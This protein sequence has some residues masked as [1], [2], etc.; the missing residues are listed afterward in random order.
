[1]HTRNRSRSR[2][3]A[4]NGIVRAFLLTAP[5]VTAFATGAPA[6]VQA[7]VRGPLALA[8]KPLT[9]GELG[10][11][12]GGFAFGGFDIDVGVVARSVIDQTLASVGNIGERLEV[13]TR[14]TVP[15]VGR[16]SHAGT[17]VQ[18]LGAAAS[19]S[20]A[21]AADGVTVSA[22]GM[23]TV[24]DIGGTTRLTQ[25]MLNTFI[26]N[27]DVDRVITNQLDINLKVGGVSRQLGAAQAA[28]A[29]R[30]TIQAQILYGPR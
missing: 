15:A 2:R 9:D 7:D 3:A 27:A 12:R 10:S 22:Q 17:T 24:V 18:A 13:V 8:A 29:M 11:F 19:E 1:M 25:N 28:R 4:A 20:G 21:A 30:P 23:S 26:E 5:L 6:P 16:L 14:F